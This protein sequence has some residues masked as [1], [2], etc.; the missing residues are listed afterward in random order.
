M[1]KSLF[2]QLA[3]NPFESGMEEMRQ[4]HENVRRIMEESFRIRQERGIGMY[5]DRVGER[6]S[7]S[8]EKIKSE[9]EQTAHAE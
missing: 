7:N 4:R 3:T 1:I 6:M 5:F 8:W 9:Q 2:Q